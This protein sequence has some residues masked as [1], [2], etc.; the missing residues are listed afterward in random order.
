MRAPSGSPQVPHVD[1]SLKLSKGGLD[2]MALPFMK[3]AV[4]KAMEVGQG[5]PGR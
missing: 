1:M 4:R 3:K 2:L 5:P